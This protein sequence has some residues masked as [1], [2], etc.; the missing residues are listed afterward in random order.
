MLINCAST[1]PVCSHSKYI[2]ISIL[3]GIKL[4]Q[5]MEI[6]QMVHITSLAVNIQNA[7]VLTL[8]TEFQICVT[9]FA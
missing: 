5:T 6:K 3:W 1:S 2:I 7:V 9:F 8:Y 4:K